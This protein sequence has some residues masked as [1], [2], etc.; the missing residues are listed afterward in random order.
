MWRKRGEGLKQK[1]SVKGKKEDVAGIMAKFFVAIAYGKGVIGCHQ[2]KG[3]VNGEMF[4]E[5]VRVVSERE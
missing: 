4:S 1:C 5:F 2:Y 3:R